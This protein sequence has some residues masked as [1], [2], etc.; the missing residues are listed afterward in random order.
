MATPGH[1]AVML[2]I[3]YLLGSIPF[4]RL[5]T[6]RAGVDLPLAAVLVVPELPTDIRHNSKI[7]R[8]RLSVWAD[9]VCAGRKPVAP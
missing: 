4:A 1:I 7:D 9:A 6:V 5:I 3:G 2:V 8:S